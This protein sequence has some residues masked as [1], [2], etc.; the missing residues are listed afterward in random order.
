MSKS[1]RVFLYIILP[2]GHLS[3]RGDVSF[4]KIQISNLTHLCIQL[5][6]EKNKNAKTHSGRTPQNVGGRV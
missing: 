4:D 5:K 3:F 6:K 1:K 2:S